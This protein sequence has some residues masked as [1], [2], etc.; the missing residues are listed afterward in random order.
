MNLSQL[1]PEDPQVALAK[2]AVNLVELA[3]KNKLEPTIGRQEEINRIIQ[4]L[5]R[6]TKNNPVLIGSP[7]VGKTAIIEGLAQRMARGDIPSNLKNKT[8]HQLDMGALIAGAKF[9]GQFE[10]RLKAVLKCVEIAN[11]TII[12]FIDEIHLI[13]GTGR[14]EG[15]MDASNLLKPMLARGELRC[16]G[17]TTADEHRKYIEKDAALERRF[18]KVYI[19]ESTVKETIS[20]LRG[21]KPRYE[22]YHGVHIHDNAIIAAA[23]MA[24]RYIP[25]RFLPDKAI[26]LIDEA[27]AAI[28]TEMASIPKELDDLNRNIMQIQIERA[29]LKGEKEAKAKARLSELDNEFSLLTSQQK[30]MQQAW[31]KENQNIQKVKQQKLRL[32]QLTQELEQSQN[33]GDYSRAG[34]I[35]YSLLPATKKALAASQKLITNSKFIKEDVTEEEIANIVAKWTHIPVTKIAE[36]ER[37]KLMH[38]E[39][40]LAKAVIGQ[41]NAL[42]QVAGAILRSRS[43]IKDPT[44]PIGSFLF[45]GPTGVGKTE[46]AKALAETMFDNQNN[47]IHLDMSE[48][49]ERHSTSKLIGS[50][51]GY[52]GYE[53]GGGL[54]EKVR[55][56][57]YSI[58]LF[59]EIEKAHRD[60]YNI[61]LQILDEGHLTD[62][63][64][65]QVDFKNTIIILTSNLNQANLQSENNDVEVS[66]IREQLSQALSPELVNRI[67]NIVIFNALSRA[68]IKAIINLELQ[69]LQT[70]LINSK[71]IQINFTKAVTEQILTAAYSRQFGARPIKHY[72][73]QNLENI[74]AWQIIAEEIKP[75]QEYEMDYDAATSSYVIHMQAKIWN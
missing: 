8:I 31:D 52:V 22:A 36:S 60:V 42:T 53:Q 14:T 26:D 72:I 41:D 24:D 49:K 55:L 11:A 62:N 25:D 19:N 63:L 23:E 34:E 75:H 58:I 29:A 27:S 45:L 40:S 3:K 71:D 61:L 32:E 66:N 50:P 12:L 4:I 67:D 37:H 20:I 47:L 30:V 70:R 1:K 9:Q 65:H 74:L 13:V 57:P 17:A 10:E 64:G 38:L 2:Y 21:L 16:I 69:H 73:S 15:A 7:G 33:K 56:H 54:T 28:Q 18:Q 44:K 51:P 59:D 43:G 6:K 39:D 48:Y 68:K 35:K 5:S 46:L